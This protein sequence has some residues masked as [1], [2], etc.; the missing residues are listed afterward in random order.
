M[1]I[2]FPGLLRSPFHVNAC[3][4]PALLRGVLFTPILTEPNTY[5]TTKK[6]CSH[7]KEVAWLYT[8][9]ARM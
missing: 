1:I 8:S 4:T 7:V 6:N 5:H 3:L 2:R 9:K